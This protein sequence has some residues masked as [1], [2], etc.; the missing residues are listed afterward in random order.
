MSLVEKL[1]PIE[2][3]YF[4]WLNEHHSPYWDNFMELYSGKIVWLPLVIV[5]LIVYIYKIKWKEA[6]VLILCG[7]LVGVLCDQI[8]SSFIKPFFE[9]YRPTH[10]PDFKDLVSVVRGYRGG[11][12]GFVSSHAANGFGIVAF[13]SLL[14]KYRPYTIFA[15]VWASITCY[16]RIY[17]GVHFITDILGG[18]VLGVLAGFFCHFIYLSARHYIL[19]VPKEELCVPVLSHN[20]ARILMAT[21]FLT[22]VYI[23][24]YSVFANG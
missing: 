13:T 3:N 7:A 9:R 2:R 19:K 22:V 12:L 24:V 20:R 23:S 17:L 14:F 16:S 8:S 5:V 11:R 18:I 4:L 6:L 15:I 10:H 21:I 1:L